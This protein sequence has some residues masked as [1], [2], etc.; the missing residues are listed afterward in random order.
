M[1]TLKY[2]IKKSHPDWSVAKQHCTQARRLYNSM[3]SLARESERFH[4]GETDLPMSDIY[5]MRPWV[6]SKIYPGSLGAFTLPC[7]QVISVQDI[8]L[9][10]K[11][12]QG[13]SRKLSQDWKSVIALRKKGLKTGS[14]RYKKTYSLVEYNPQAISTRSLK[15]GYLCPT[16]WSTGVK[17]PP[18]INVRSARIHHSHNDVFILEVLYQEAPD[19]ESPGNLTASIDLG[20]NKLATIV[21]E[22]GSQP[23][24][25]SGLEAKSVNQGANRNNKIKEVR[26]KQGMWDKRTRRVN[27]YLH[28]ASSAVVKDLRERG[29]GELIIGWNEGFK[30]S[31][32]MGR[33]GN[34]RFVNMPLA[35][36]RD[37]LTY[38][39]QSQGIN[40]IIQEE[41]YTSKSS[42]I[43]NDPIPCYPSCM[44]N[45]SGKRVKRGLYKSS[46]GTTIHADVNGAYNI[47]RKRKPSFGWSR[48]FV[49]KPT[50]LAFSY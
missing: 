23:L 45:F 3:N 25:V 8:K 27:H 16:G 6:T 46:D 34:Q 33:K 28:S 40:V 36:F 18:D 14:V 2:H 31:P 29:V 38:K 44:N 13:V 7:K 47:L 19:K 4:E 41:S 20:I 50:N 26:N 12:A 39:A 24:S 5:N 21:F 49:V 42:F 32:T 48:G 15:K 43:D 10:A 35:R 37:M 1:R 11:V 22:D 30:D 9:P 17:L